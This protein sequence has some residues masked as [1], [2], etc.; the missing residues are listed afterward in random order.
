MNMS[1]M[2]MTML[3]TTFGPRQAT[4]FDAMDGRHTAAATR[5]QG[6]VRAAEQQE[7]SARWGGGPRTLV[8]EREG[9][10]E[11]QTRVR[12]FQRLFS[13]PFLVAALPSGTAVSDGGR[14]LGGVFF[15]P[16]GSTRLEQLQ[17]GMVASE[18]RCAQKHGRAHGRAA[19][20][21]PRAL[22]K[23]S[24]KPLTGSHQRDDQQPY[25]IRTMP[26]L[27]TRPYCT[28]SRAEP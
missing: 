22:N 1:M 20:S 25:L 27:Y 4:D 17:L 10:R 9:E 21:R 16:A 15:P 19:P 26:Q 28:N 13:P 3:T 18:E 23:C 5:L 7:L 14:F 11:R 24:A 8:R 2:T 6:L 12:T